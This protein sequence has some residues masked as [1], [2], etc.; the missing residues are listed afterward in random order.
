VDDLGRSDF[1]RLQDRAKRRGYR[2]GDDPVV[3][4]AFDVLVHCD[5][6]VRSLP[7]AK[8]KAMLRRVL[9]WQ[10]ASVLMVQDLPGRGSWLYQQACELRLEGIVSKRLD[11]PYLSG[12]R[13][14][15]WV[16]VKRPSALP[17][18]RFHRGAKT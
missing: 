17:P 6:D 15:D 4:C 13:S 1:D 5:L 14:G 7:L 8:R 2:E 3:Y 9:R 11:S 18:E 10:L 16:K 12:V